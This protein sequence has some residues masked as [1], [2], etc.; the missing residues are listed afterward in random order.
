MSDYPDHNLSPSEAEVMAIEDLESGAIEP[1]GPRIITPLDKLEARCQGVADGG[2]RKLPIAT[3]RLAIA[4]NALDRAQLSGDGPS[5][6]KFR[7]TAEQELI[8]C[9]NLLSGIEEAQRRVRR[10][11][12][13]RLRGGYFVAAKTTDEAWAI[14]QLRI[15]SNM[16]IAASRGDR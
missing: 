2:M 12:E 5:T 6:L 1:E 3:R 7:I 8:K 16:Q 15:V 13:V 4:M 9:Q 14:T 10:C 11:R